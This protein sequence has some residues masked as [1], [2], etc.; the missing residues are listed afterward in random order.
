MQPELSVIIP[1]YNEE[2]VLPL[3]AHRLRPILDGLETTYEVVAVD[4][5][6][7]DASAVIL[8]RLRREWPEMRIVRLRA[9]AGHQAA[10]SAGCIPETSRSKMRSKNS[11][12]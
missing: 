6:N 7:T 10:I 5:G 8:Q 11:A 1:V 9:N 2:E 12:A 3:L 4:D